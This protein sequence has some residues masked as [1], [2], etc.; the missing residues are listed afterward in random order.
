MTI[1][2]FTHKKHLY[3]HTHLNTRETYT[4]KHMYVQIWPF[5]FKDAITY[6]STPLYLYRYVTAILFL[7]ILQLVF[8]GF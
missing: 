8:Y 5:I 1:N 3:I 6:I 7:S 4:N 2:T